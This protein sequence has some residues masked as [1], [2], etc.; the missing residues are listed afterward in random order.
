MDV[1]RAALTSVLN[2]AARLHD[3]HPYVLRAFLSIVE[4]YQC[5]YSVSASKIRAV[6]DAVN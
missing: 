4:R 3:E 2:Q 1:K 5:F 6:R